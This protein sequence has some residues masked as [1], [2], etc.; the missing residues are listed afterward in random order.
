MRVNVYHP[1]LWKGLREMN[2]PPPTSKNIRTHTINDMCN[3]TRKYPYFIE[4]HNR[5]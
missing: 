1:A 4:C 5:K 2:Y 3:Y